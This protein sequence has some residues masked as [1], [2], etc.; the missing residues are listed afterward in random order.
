MDNFLTHE[1]ALSLALRVILGI[2]FLIQGYDK[3]FNIGMDGVVR[4]VNEQYINKGFP[5]WMVTIISYLTTYIEFLAGL[6]LVLGLFKTIAFYSLL[7]DLGIVSFGMSILN[8]L[9]D[10]RYV[11]PRLVLLIVLMMLPDGWDVC[12]IDHIKSIMNE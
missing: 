4:T 5:I 2:M 8:P 11:W 3:I 6:M 10:M 7:L 9:W 1:A 12:S